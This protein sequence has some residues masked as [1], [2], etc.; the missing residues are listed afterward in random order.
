MTTPHPEPH[1]VLYEFMEIGNSVRVA[2]VDP[3][4]LVEVVV[5]GPPYAM[6]MLKRTA[7][8]KL[9]NAIARQREAERSGRR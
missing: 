4:T 6:E 2:A 8:R 1:Q 5:V 9:A 7:R 3:A